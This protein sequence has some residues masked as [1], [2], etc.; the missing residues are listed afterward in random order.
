MANTKEYTSFYEI[1]S[2]LVTIC[3]PT[4]NRAD[5]LLTRSLKSAVQQTY[6]HLEIIVVG[7]CCTDHTVEV[8]CGFNDPRIRF[9]NMSNRGQYPD[10]PFQ[11]W[12]VAGSIPTNRA[13]ELAS[14]HFITHL[15]DDD[16]FALDRIEKLLDFA[17]YS[18]ADLIYHPFY[19][20][21]YKDQRFQAKLKQRAP[22][23]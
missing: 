1:E 20:L 11:R 6:S 19:Y 15:D 8:V 14:G 3:I 13:L 17:K 9:E 16:E 7:D 5:T 23:E 18:R 10:D 4:Y 12:M 21:F 22:I 2:P